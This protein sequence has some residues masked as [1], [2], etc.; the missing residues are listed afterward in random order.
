MTLLA[1][2]PR[3]ESLEDRSRRDVARVA[4]LGVPLDG[5]QPRVVGR[6]HGFDDA[7]RGR[8]DDIEARAEVLD[9]LVMEAGDGDR[10]SD[11]LVQP[12]ALRERDVVG[13]EVP[14]GALRVLDGV[15]YLAR[16]VLV[17]GAAVR[18]VD[19]LDAAA[20]REDR[21]AP[22][23]GLRE[24]RQLVGVAV[25]RGGV[26]LRVGLLAVRG[27]VD[28]DPTR[29]EQPV[30]VGELLGG[31]PPRTARRRGARAASAGRPPPAPRPR[32]RPA[33]R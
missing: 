1:S 17:E 20:D 6:L 16:D 5:H 23:L 19:E 14:R 18:D 15:G 12:A 33:R 21:D 7:V 28:V 27:G 9:R 8:G 25:G 24:Q 11:Q 10:A 13:R 32:S 31:L 26:E 3:D 4:H 2:A 22:A 29:Q 30:A